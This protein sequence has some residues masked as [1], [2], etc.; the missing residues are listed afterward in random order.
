MNKVKLRKFKNLKKFFKIVI[1]GLA[2]EKQN[3]FTSQ[4]CSHTLMQT[5]LSSNQS[6]R[7]ILVI[8]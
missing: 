1:A 2:R 7:T 6:A 8:S 5:G 3:I 4:P